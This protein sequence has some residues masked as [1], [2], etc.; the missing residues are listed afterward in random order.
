[1]TPSVRSGLISFMNNG[2]H[3]TQEGKRIRFQGPR[4]KVQ[5]ELQKENQR[6]V[7][8]K[9]DQTGSEHKEGV[10][11][12]IALQLIYGELGLY[13]TSNNRSYCSGST[14]ITTDVI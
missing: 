1:M 14:V 7:V 11:Q 13:L 8:H 2:T 5:N 10:I 12:V 6:G 4:T 9:R 3:K